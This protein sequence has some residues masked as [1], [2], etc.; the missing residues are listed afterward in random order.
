MMFLLPI[1]YVSFAIHYD[2][3]YVK[4]MA[5]KWKMLFV[6]N[7]HNLLL[8]GIVM[9]WFIMTTM[10]IV[11][12]VRSEIMKR[13][14]C[15][16]NFEDDD[17]LAQAEFERIKK[18]IGIKGK[19]ELYHNDDRRVRSPFV[20]GFLRCKVVLPYNQFSGDELKVILYHELNHVKKCD[21]VFRYLTMLAIIVNCM[22]PIAYL[23][24]KQILTWSEADCDARAIDDLEKEGI[25]KRKYYE[26]IWFLMQLGPPVASIFYNPMLLDAKNSFYRRIEIMEKYKAN[27]KKMAKSVT[28]AWVMIFAMFSSVTA[29]A[30]GF[31]LAEAGDEV[32]K[33]TQS[34]SQFDAS[35]DVLSWSDEMVIPA[36]DVVNIV[37]VND[38][39]MPLG[40]A[41]FTWDVPI[42]T[43]CVSASIYLTKD[44]E[45]QIA[46]TATPNNCLYWFGLMH[47][48][49]DCYVV[50]GTG[51]GSHAFTV[52]KTGYYRIMVENRGSVALRVAGSY[53]Y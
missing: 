12:T 32:L 52:P 13:D 4:P 46:C 27:M 8:Q 11:L 19:V 31:G 16:S 17:S 49:S 39:I 6:L 36:N 30:A 28:F 23:L 15:K 10:M 18:C 9:I 51:Q 1:T 29:H 37:Y 45:V 44:T 7:S 21:I 42:E 22:N 20:T 48:S 3:G 50:E 34:V 26:T 14:I 41:T 25:S 2:A 5:G 43:R 24:W 33:E 35:E 53:A 47:S 40:Q 38:G